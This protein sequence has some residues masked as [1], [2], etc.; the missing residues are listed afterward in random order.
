MVLDPQAPIRY[1]GFSFMPDGYGPALANEF[2]QRGTA[3]IPVEILKLDLP[4]IW[5]TFQRSVFA[6]ASVQQAEYVKLRGYLSINEPGYG[7][8]RCLYEINPSMPCQSEFIVKDYIFNIDDLLLALDAASNHI[9]TSTSPMD[10]HIAAFI[11]ARFEEDIHP[12]LKAL[13]SPTQETATVG[14]LSLLAFLQWK[15]RVNALFGL[16]SWV[17]GLLGPAINTLLQPHDP[18]RDRTGNPAPGAQGQPARA[19]RS[20]RQRRKPKDRFRRI[21]GRGNRIC[22]RR[23]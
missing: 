7:F 23:I 20:D 17:G 4:L 14:L 19:F 8:E 1:K 21:R 2:L 16:S 13:A 22:R 15:L 5:Y 3:E 11:A 10:A 12:H 6:G 9:D 18:A